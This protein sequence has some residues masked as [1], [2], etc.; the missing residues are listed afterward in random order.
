MGD[1]QL[2]SPEEQIRLAREAF[3]AG[4]DYTIAVEEEFMLLDPETLELTNRFEELK[5]GAAGTELDDHLVGELIA[6]EIEVKTGR[7]LN[8]SEAA[9]HMA[10]RRVQLAELA[11][12]FGVGLASTGTH[13]WSRWQDQRIIDT[14]HYRRNNE[15]LQY[16][17]WRNNSFGIHAHIG[18]RGADRAIAV[19][20]AFR[21]VLPELLALSA[22]SPFVE[23]CVTGLHSVRTEIFTKMFP[24]C[25]VPDAYEG[26]ADYEEYVR[27]LY[28]TGS[29]DEHTQIWWSVRPHLA[30]PTVE[31]RICDAQ[32]DLVEAQGLAALIYALAVRFARALDEGEPLP[33]LP[34]RLIEENLWRA[35]RYGLGGELIDFDRGDVVPAR[36]RIEALIDWVEPVAREIGAAPYL[37]VPDANAAERQYERVAELGSH[38]DVFAELVRR[39]RERV[40]G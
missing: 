2:L 9:E 40:G 34:H 16:V 31:V 32:P 13:P 36:T 25:G 23:D 30:F 26:W 20:N 39:P 11:D 3:E 38:R 4:D 12:E 22:S 27:F 6:S 28:D 10:R 24:R 5:A 15:I 29:I 19:C 8:F 18:I 14:P 33:D 1:E 37:R 21:N 35:I 17:V 7:C